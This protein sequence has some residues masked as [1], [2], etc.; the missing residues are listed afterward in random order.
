MS[1]AVLKDGLEEDNNDE[2]I[3]VVSAQVS[4][5]GV[6][7]IFG[8]ITE[9]ISDDP[10]HII[11]RI[12]NNIKAHIITSERKNIDVLKQKAFETGVFVVKVTSVEPEIEV[13]CKAV[14]FGKSQ[15]YNA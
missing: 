3:K 1:N 2:G 10:E 5:G 11:A 9:M 15:A 7:P 8:M 4:V 13:E 6:Y 14:I 12:N